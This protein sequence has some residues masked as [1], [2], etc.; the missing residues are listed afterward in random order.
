MI[1]ARNKGFSSGEF[2]NR[3][4]MLTIIKGLYF[5]MIKRSKYHTY[6]FL[7]HLREPDY[8]QYKHVTNSNLYRVRVRAYSD[9]SDP[10][11]VSSI[12]SSS[13]LPL[14]TSSAVSLL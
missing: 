11:L 3:R 5:Q 9:N 7:S 10:E 2:S 6:M 14:V 1:R 4:F 13:G 8:Y 12:V